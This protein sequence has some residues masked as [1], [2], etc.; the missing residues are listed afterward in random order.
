[1]GPSHMV[2]I[3]EFQMFLDEHKVTHEKI[4]QHLSGLHRKMWN[5][6]MGV[7]AG[8]VTACGALVLILVG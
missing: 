3:R 4:D 8:L 2:S 7:I 6:A 1:M 5:V